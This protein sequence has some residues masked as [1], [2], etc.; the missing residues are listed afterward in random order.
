MFISYQL[1]KSRFID[2]LGGGSEGGM[3]SLSPLSLDLCT[4]TRSKRNR[5]SIYRTVYIMEETLCR[6][7]LGPKETRK[8]PFIRPCLCSGSVAHVHKACFD[9]WRSMATLPEHKRRCQLCLSE[10]TMVRKWPSDTI[11]KMEDKGL[12]SILSRPFACNGIVFVTH[13]AICIEYLVT[14]IKRQESQESILVE[15]GE[16]EAIVYELTQ[17]HALYCFLVLLALLTST[18]VAVYRNN[19]ASIKNKL[20]YM[21]YW[22]RG[23]ITYYT[24]VS[25]RMYILYMLTSLAAMWYGTFLFGIVF[26]FLLPNWIEVHKGILHAINDD[27]EME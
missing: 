17:P 15:R 20:R 3:Q 13:Y 14:P 11:L 27:G 26:I 19:I 2:F 12:W 25:P 9:K 18:Y 5:K 6:F 16:R 1:Y 8:N 10:F 21:A 7:C 24:D 23:D 22:L 4:I